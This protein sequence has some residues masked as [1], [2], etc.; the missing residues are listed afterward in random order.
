LNF[1][2]F[3]KAYKTKSPIDGQQIAIIVFVQKYPAGFLARHFLWRQ[4]TSNQNKKN[5]KT[6]IRPQLEFLQNNVLPTFPS[7]PV[8]SVTHRSVTFS[9][10]EKAMGD[11]SS[12]EFFQSQVS[13]QDF[14]HS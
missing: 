1:V 14:L 4:E 8:T 5:I 3:G 10:P 6:K 9:D 7:W 12:A 2:P 13:S 11:S